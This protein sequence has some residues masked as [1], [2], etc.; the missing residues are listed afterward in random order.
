MVNLWR[1]KIRSTEVRLCSERANWQWM[2]QLTILFH[3]QLVVYPKK[4]NTILKHRVDTPLDQPGDKISWVSEPQPYRQLTRMADLQLASVG[5]IR[6]EYAA[7][8][9]LLLPHPHGHHT[10]KRDATRNSQYTTPHVRTLHPSTKHQSPYHLTSIPGPISKAAHSLINPLAQPAKKQGGM[11]SGWCPVVRSALMANQK[12]LPECSQYFLWGSSFSAWLKQLWKEAAHSMRQ[13]IPWDSIWIG[14]WLT[15]PLSSLWP[16]TNLTSGCLSMSG[17]L[18]RLVKSHSWAQDK[19]RA[20]TSACGISWRSFRWSYFEN[21][22][23]T[24]PG[25]EQKGV[26]GEANWLRL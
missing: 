16:Q 13:H 19:P 5:P 10:P 1:S 12:K 25:R 7:P 4:P 17:K 23:V 22:C 6:P 14:S 11:R 26:H 21:F 20:V 24:F 8:Q 15:S 3:L 9:I 18:V 2:Q